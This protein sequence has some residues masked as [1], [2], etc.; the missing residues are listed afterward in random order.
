MRG[1][2][3]SFFDGKPGCQRPFKGSY[4]KNI[5]YTAMHFKICTAFNPITHLFATSHPDKCKADDRRQCCVCSSKK[6]RKTKKRKSESVERKTLSC[7]SAPVISLFFYSQSLPFP[8]SSL[9]FHF[10]TKSANLIYANLSWRNRK[11]RG[12]SLN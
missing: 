8:A 4:M 12:M 9:P 2:D 3:S 7:R 11:D 10:K 6:K 5:H 1:Q